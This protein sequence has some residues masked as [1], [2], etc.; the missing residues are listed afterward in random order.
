[1]ENVFG[2]YF[3][4]FLCFRIFYYVLLYRYNI[5]YPNTKPIKA[6]VNLKHPLVSICVYQGI[7]EEI[8]KRMVYVRKKILNL[9][10]NCVIKCA[11]TRR[12]Y[13]YSKV[14]RMCCARF[15]S[16]GTCRTSNTCILT[17]Y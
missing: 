2:S 17:Y 14:V 7:Y 9:F 10:I 12:D 13:I 3:F 5:H 1:M 6:S 16:T 4:T 15:F 8:V 11:L